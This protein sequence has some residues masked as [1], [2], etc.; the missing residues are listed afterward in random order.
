MIYKHID[1]EEFNRVLR[2]QIGKAY[3]YGVEVKVGR[4]A[5]DSAPEWDCSE[6][7][8]VHF[9]LYESSLPDGSQ[10]QFDFCKPVAECAVG[11][12]GFSGTGPR[13]INHVFY[14][15]SKNQVIEAR[16]EPYNRVILRPRA[17]WEAWRGFQGWRMVPDIRFYYGDGRP[18]RDYTKI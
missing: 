13:G 2:R 16:G 4:K 11:D 14:L 12:L 10:N 17:A 1:I 8:Q 9:N 5:I 15:I 7:L 6:I 18:V 3:K